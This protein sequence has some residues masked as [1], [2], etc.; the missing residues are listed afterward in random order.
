MVCARCARCGCDGGSP[1]RRKYFDDIHRRPLLFSLQA[2]F[3]PFPSCEGVRCVPG[4]GFTHTQTRKHANT[5]NTHIVTHANLA[6]CICRC[7][8]QSGTRPGPPARHLFSTYI[9]GG[10]HALEGVRDR[11][12]VRADVIVLEALARAQEAQRTTTHPPLVMLVLRALRY[13]RAACR[14]CLRG[15]V[16]GLIRTRPRNPLGR[17]AG[18]R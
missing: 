1:D 18:A 11:Q 3:T 15:G 4:E 8:T 12:H 2:S 6:F 10:R 13:M 5:P 17:G 16:A 14:V 9:F 7:F